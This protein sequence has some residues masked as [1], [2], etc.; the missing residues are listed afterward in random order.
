MNFLVIGSGGREHALVWKLQQ[1]LADSDTVYVTRANPGIR[2]LKNVKNIAISPD[3]IS[4]LVDFADQNKVYMTFTGSENQIA[5]GIVDD[6]QAR[7]LSIFGPTKEA[8]RI[9]T[10]KAHAKRLMHE[11]RIPTA[12]PFYILDDLSDARRYALQLLQ[13]YGGAVMKADGLAQGKGV[14]VCRIE[15]EIDN[16]IR[17]ISEDKDLKAAAG[18][19]I[20]E[21][22]LWGE[23]ASFIVWTDGYHIIP[24][25]TTQ[26]HKPVD[27]G[28]IGPN[29]GGMGVHTRPRVT[30]GMDGKIIREIIRP[31]V[32]SMSRY[33]YKGVLYAGLM[34][35][36][37]QPYV[38]E[39][40]AR[41]G[42]PEMQSQ[43]MLLKSSLVDI[44]NACI[45]E[46]LDKI[47]P[48]WSDEEAACVVLASKGYPG[49]YSQN[50]GK[51]IHIAEHLP[52]YAAVFHAGTGYK[53][54]KIVN[55]GGRVLG[56]TARG[57]DLDT[58]LRRVY[59]LIDRKIVF[60]EDMHFRRDI[61][62][63]SLIHLK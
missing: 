27:D 29:T 5:K 55:T 36:D 26:D 41:Y 24:L 14:F 43:M 59:D 28:D 4:A 10:S 1:E 35:V 17:R 16:A 13:P 2:N 49:D 52:D 53:D 9:E 33:P 37:G 32:Q 47:K 31:A 38:L 51:E 56:V 63:R 7:G 30:R 18:R 40:N 12:E 34:V 48:E 6:F 20:V 39:F 54:G 25:V 8:A 46:N 19:M 3:N 58:A 61:G 44:S 42:D 23:E 60:F 21:R 22:P 57:P 62:Y 15:E 50:I 11:N 45:E